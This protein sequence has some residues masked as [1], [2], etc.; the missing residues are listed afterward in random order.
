MCDEPI[1]ALT[2]E[3]MKRFPDLLGPDKYFCLLGS[4]HVEKAILTMCGEII[5]GSG[6]EGKV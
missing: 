4:L 6:L 3:L 5:K 2:Q 1:F